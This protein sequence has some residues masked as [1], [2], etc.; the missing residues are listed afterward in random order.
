MPTQKHTCP[1]CNF[2]TLNSKGGFE[3]CIICWWEDDGQNDSDA[4]KVRGGPNYI[5]SL[6]LARQNFIHY[7]H[8]YNEGQGIDVVVRPSEQRKELLSYLGSIDA[9][10]TC[11][12]LTRF[13]KP[14][15]AVD[16]H[17]RSDRS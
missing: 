3:I 16:Y 5:Y 1:C 11:M 14:L 2:P 13:D 10:V 8:M 6:T 4:D 7:G 15:S 9:N 12:N 17:L